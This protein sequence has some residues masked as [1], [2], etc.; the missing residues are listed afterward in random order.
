MSSGGIA[1][2]IYGFTFY[3]RT[4]I[5]ANVLDFAI[6]NYGTVLYESKGVLAGFSRQVVTSDESLGVR[7]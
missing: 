1:L 4:R 6:V 2:I 7:V 3:D 5:T